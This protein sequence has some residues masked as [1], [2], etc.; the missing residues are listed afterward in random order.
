MELQLDKLDS[1]WVLRP[2]GEMNIY[3]AAADKAP[4]LAALA[5]SPAVELDLSAVTEMD[6]SGLQLLLLLAAEAR[7]SGKVVRLG[8][9][10]KPAEEVLDLAGVRGELTVGTGPEG[11]AA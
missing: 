10:S 5:E 1:H 2:V 8:E 7:R 11:M 3:R 9:C 6:T 4:L